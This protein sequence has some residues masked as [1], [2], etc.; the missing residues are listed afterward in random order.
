MKII[1]TDISDLLVIE[2]T[3]YTDA[4]GYFFESY[5]AS[6]W[7]KTM[8]TQSW[9]QDN[10]SQSTKGVLRGLHYQR[11]DMAQ[12]KLVRAITG[13]IYDIA[14]DLRPDS[15]SYGKWFGITLTAEN[16]KQLY[17]P[18]G[19]AHG[20][21]VLSEE[22]VFAYK[23]DNYYSKEDEGGIIYNDPTLNIQW[24]INTSLI[25]LSEKDKVLPVFGNH[26]SF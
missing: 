26:K 16:K 2:P 12:A 25:Q 8:T 5:N 7:P 22:A 21:V 4:R 15:E 13:E 9:V 23:C 11:G 18:R 1:A 10:E 6:K 19:F 14:V 20:F 17:I 24:P 3:V